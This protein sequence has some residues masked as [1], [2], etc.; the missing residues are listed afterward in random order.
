[1]FHKSHVCPVVNQ[2]YAQTYTR[3]NARLI[4]E[5]HCLPLCVAGGEIFE[6]HQIEIRQAGDTLVKEE[7]NR[8]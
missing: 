1:M 7:E 3:F 8:N 6:N 2:L 5:G 4:N